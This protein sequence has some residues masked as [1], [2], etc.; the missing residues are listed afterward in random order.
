MFQVSLL[1]G[2]V[3]LSFLN[4]SNTLQETVDVLTK[5]GCSEQASTIFKQAVERYYAA[6][7]DFNLSKFPKS[8]DGFYSFTTVK[9]L[10]TALP[11]RLS[12]TGHAW[13]FNCFD[14]VIV[15]AD[16]QLRTELRPDE[17]VGPFMVSMATTNGEVV[18]F[19]AT[20][21]DAFTRANP[22][23]YRETTESIIPDSMRDTR[24][25]LTAELFQ[26]HLLPLSASEETEKKDVIKVL[27]ASW[28]RE[29]LRFPRRCEIVL[30]HKV[31]LTA[32]T[33]CTCHAGLLLHSKEHYTFLEKTGG[34]GPFV[35][36]DFDDRSDLLY[37]LWAKFNETEHR[38]A[39][40][41]ATFNDASIDKLDFK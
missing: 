10:V 18:T 7:F 22:P 3:R 36:L 37:W 24:M 34:S 35:R 6:G 11:H 2:P 33:I 17:I 13:D 16:G 38:N 26:W 20:A 9:E 23:W 40:L 5:S 15:L 27:Q 21:R 30:S 8:Q 28:Q 41:F 12:D 14:T 25:C 39:Q 4:D 1:A 19:A 32:H 31:D 29:K